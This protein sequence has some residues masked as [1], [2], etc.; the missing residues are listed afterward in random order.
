M[1]RS[2]R[3]DLCGGRSVMIVPTASFVLWRGSGR[4]RGSQI[5]LLH[6]CRGEDGGMEVA[7]EQYTFVRV[8]AREGEES[9]VED[10]LRDVAGPTRRRRAA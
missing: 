8:H 6:T 5:R 10:A 3:T 4:F 7:M 2:A 9:T 1:R